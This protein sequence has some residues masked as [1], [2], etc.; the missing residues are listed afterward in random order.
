MKKI[1]YIDLFAGA[2]GWSCGFER[3]EAFKHLRMYDINGSACDT[4]RANFGNIVE[5]A[6]LAKHEEIEFPSADVIIG[7]PPCQGFSNEGTKNPEDPRNSLVWAFLD[8]IEKNKPKVWVFE[9]VPGF[10]RSYDGKWFYEMSKRLNKSK[11]KWTCGIVNAADFGVPQNRKRFIA[12]GA[13]DF[14]P[15]LPP[16]SHFADFDISPESRHVT[17]WEAISDLPKPKRGDRIGTFEY[18]TE[19]HSA[20]QKWARKGSVSVLNHT[21]QNHSQ[22]VLEKIKLVPAGKNMAAFLG[23]FSEN[24][25]NYAGG[26]RRAPKHL[27]SWTAYWT[28]GMTSIHPTQH[29]FLTPRECARIQSFP[30]R[31][32][33]TGS[34]IEN[35][36]Q[37]CNAVPPLLSEAVGRHIIKMLDANK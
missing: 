22:R 21:A 9:N 35:Y 5:E 1:T 17:I 11:Y 27:P 2:G 36:T 8:I 20:Y 13:L 25:T 26:Y 29:R 6:D 19:P 30:D 15:T 37:I 33:F 18:Q 16:Q 12:I 7:S 32:I 4:A 28:R 24:S 23:N 34:T 3:I 31:H 14:T 10:Q